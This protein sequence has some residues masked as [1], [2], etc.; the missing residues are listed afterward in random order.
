[1]KKDLIGLIVYIFLIISMSLLA[2][3]SFNL[4][5]FISFRET[6]EFTNFFALYFVPISLII[7][8]III[9]TF[10]IL[11]KWSRYLDVFFNQLKFPSILLIAAILVIFIFRHGELLSFYI[12]TIAVSY[13]YAYIV[14]LINNIGLRLK[15]EH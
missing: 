14:I 9:T 2:D 5:E 6:S 10:A 4:F 3:I 7:L 15:K 11:Q 8:P 13:C 12:S 1:M